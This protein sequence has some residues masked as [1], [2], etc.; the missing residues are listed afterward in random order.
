[1]YVGCIALN[2]TVGRAH[3]SLLIIVYESHIV[4][5]KQKI[6]PRA[7]CLPTDLYILDI[8]VNISRTRQI[9]RYFEKDMPA[10]MPKKNL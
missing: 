6:S 7:G 1:M 5:F 8:C 3:L 9:C 4:K 2:S 10:K